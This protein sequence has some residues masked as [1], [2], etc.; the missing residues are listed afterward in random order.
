MRK[1]LPL[2]ILCGIASTL[3]AQYDSVWLYPQGVPGAIVKNIPEK[4]TVNPQDGVT[5]TGD[6]QKPLLYIHRPAKPNGVA[7]LICPGGGYY[8]LAMDHE[9]HNIARWFTERGITA[10]VL[11]SRLPDDNL[12][13]Q[14]TIRP[15]QDAQQAMRIIRGNAAR[16]KIDPS[17][18]GIMGFSAGGHLASTVGT[19]FNKQVGEITDPK[20]SVRPDFMI[21]GYPMISYKPGN[22]PATAPNRLLGD[23]P[24]A[25]LIEEYSNELHVTADTPPTF[26][27]LSS[28]DFLSPMNSIGFFNALLQHKVPAELHVFEKGGHG[29][30]LS[31]KHRGHVEEWDREL[32]GWLRDR[33]LM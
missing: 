21:L 4:V 26:L 19:H 5:I 27:F 6:I 10:F 30:A 24:S 7:V 33:K 20:I 9:G 3:K 25:A 22:Y 29:Y 23:K 17:K 32:E 28:D 12:M 18:L 16:W 8:V 13:T 15:L 14:K 2:L 31:K 1:L 11:K